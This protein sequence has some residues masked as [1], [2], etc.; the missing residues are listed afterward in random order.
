MVKYLKVHR[1]GSLFRGSEEFIT[2]RSMRV[3]MRFHGSHNLSS[4]AEVNAFGVNAYLIAT[5]YILTPLLGVYHLMLMRPE[6]FI[7][8]YICDML[9]L[10]KTTGDP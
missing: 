7:S 1:R 8:V 5:P 3:V 10:S 2:E 4:P 6:L 9:N